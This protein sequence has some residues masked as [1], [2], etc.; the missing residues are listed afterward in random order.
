[1]NIFKF[2]AECLH[3][4]V[5]LL[6]DFKPTKATI[7][8]EMEVDVVCTLHTVAELDEVITYMRPIA[9][10]HVMIETIKPINE[11]TGERLLG[12]TQQKYN[13]PQPQKGY[14]PA[15]ICELENPEEG[16]EYNQSELEFINDLKK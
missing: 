5:A 8:F 15:H 13:M 7:D 11:Y 4:V 2:R 10:S 16:K 14:I 6:E 9:D 12:P 3:D 1:M